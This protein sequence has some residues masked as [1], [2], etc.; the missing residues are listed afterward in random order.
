MGPRAG[1]GAVRKRKITLVRKE[2]EH[3]KRNVHSKSDKTRDV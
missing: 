3:I 2:Q 1:L